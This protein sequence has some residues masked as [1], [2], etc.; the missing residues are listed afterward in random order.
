MNQNLSEKAKDWYL[1]NI[2][3]LSKRLNGSSKNLL[4]E[5]REKSKKKFLELDFPNRK[6]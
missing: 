3:I 6:K 5:L 1:Q 4:S 2:D